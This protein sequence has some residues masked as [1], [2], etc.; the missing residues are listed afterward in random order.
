MASPWKKEKNKNMGILMLMIF[1]FMHTNRYLDGDCSELDHVE[2]YFFYRAQKINKGPTSAVE[3]K[4]LAVCM[5]ETCI[6]TL[7]FLYRS[8]SLLFTEC[9]FQLGGQHIFTWG[10]K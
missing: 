10:T 9:G 3:Y 4:L 2:F 7:F 8:V 6:G 5:H 1:Y